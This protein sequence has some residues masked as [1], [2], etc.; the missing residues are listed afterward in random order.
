VTEGY[1]DTLMGVRMC[2]DLPNVWDILLTLRWSIW[3]FDAPWWNTRGVPDELFVPPEYA[4]IATLAPN[5]FRFLHIQHIAEAD[6]RP[7][8]PM[9]EHVVATLAQQ[10][11]VQ[12]NRAQL[13]LTELQALARERVRELQEQQYSIATPS[14]LYAERVSLP[15]SKGIAAAELLPATGP[16]IVDGGMVHVHGVPYDLPATAMLDGRS[17]IVRYDPDDARCV[18]I[19]HDR[20]HVVLAYAAGFEHP[21]PWWELLSNPM[22]DTFAGGSP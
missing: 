6:T 17:V 15:W 11:H 9:L 10:Q 3:H 13:T 22:V 12:S 18:W 19:V 16:L 4:Q 5:A 2:P 8:P 7:P 21:M 20:A 1:T 14:E